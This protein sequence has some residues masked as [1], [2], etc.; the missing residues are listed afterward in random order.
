MLAPDAQ[1]GFADQAA[2]SAWCERYC[3]ELLVMELS[4]DGKPEQVIQV[5]AVSMTREG[6]RWAVTAG[7][8]LAAATPKAALSAYR[9]RLALELGAP[10]LSRSHHTRTR[11]VVAAI[12]RALASGVAEPEGGARELTIPLDGALR[13]VLL[14]EDGAW[15]LDRVFNAPSG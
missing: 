13:A 11:R 3:A 1:S 10:G 2:F 12:D 4:R 14:K 8:G 6:Q 15:R 5:G 9:A 7:P